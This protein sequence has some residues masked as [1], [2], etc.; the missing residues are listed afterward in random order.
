MASPPRRSASAMK[1]L[2]AEARVIPGPSPLGGALRG[3]RAFSSALG[4][5]KDNAYSQEQ[6]GYR[7]LEATCEW[8]G[9]TKHGEEGS[10]QC[11]RTV[12]HW[13]QIWIIVC[14]L[15]QEHR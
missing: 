11:M 5:A 15:L 2:N 4:L 8:P 7:V 6:K 3:S 9:A 12:L 14:H 13:L 10:L 1:R